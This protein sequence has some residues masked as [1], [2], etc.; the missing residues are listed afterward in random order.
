[1]LYG[2]ADKHGTFN[3]IYRWQSGLHVFEWKDEDITTVT[4]YHLQNAYSCENSQQWQYAISYY[5]VSG[6][7][8]NP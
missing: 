8:V 6:K 3:L 5:T 1:M 7:K 4:N 2:H